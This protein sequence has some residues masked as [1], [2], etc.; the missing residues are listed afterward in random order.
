MTVE[1]VQQRRGR[2]VGSDNWFTT[3]ADVLWCYKKLSKV[4]PL[5]AEPAYDLDAAACFESRWG[6]YYYTPERGENGLVLPWWGNVWV[7]MPFSRIRPWVERAWYAVTEWSPKNWA[8]SVSLLMPATKHEQPFWQEL[9]E[10]FRDRCGDRMKGM[11]PI[12]TTHYLPGR[13]SF[14]YPG[15]GGVPKKGA[16]F[17][18]VLVIFER[19]TY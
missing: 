6:T 18:C 4:D 5:T 12:I 17:G 16:S 11:E 10:P 15:S 9:I 3:K 14:A 7:N 2:K 1:L 8:D 13:T 19:F